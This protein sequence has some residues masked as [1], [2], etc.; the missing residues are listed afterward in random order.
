M[1]AMENK[2][3]DDDKMNKDFLLLSPSRRSLHRTCK[4]PLKQVNGNQKKRNR[5]NQSTSGVENREY[6]SRLA[7]GLL[8]TFPMIDQHFDV[9]KK[10]GE[11]TFSKVYLARYGKDHRRLIAIKHLIPT[12]SPSRIENELNCLKMVGGRCNVIGVECTLRVDDHIVFLLPYLPHQ[13]FTN[14][15]RSMSNISI[16]RY[17]KNLLIALNHVHKHNIIHRD[18]KPNNFIYCKE[19]KRYSLI[20]FGLAMSVPGC[21]SSLLK[22]YTSSATSRSLQHL[23]KN[24]LS[25]VNLCKHSS[26]YVCSLCKSR[27]RQSAPRAGTPGFRSP[28]VLMR[29]PNQTTAVDIWSAGVILLCILSGRYPFFKVKDD[30]DALAQ[31]VALFKIQDMKKMAS[32]IGK[33]FEISASAKDPEHSLKTMCENL[34]RRHCVIHNS[35]RNGKRKRTVDS[36]CEDELISPN[37]KPSVNHVVDC[38]KSSDSARPRD[39]IN[40]NPVT[41]CRKDRISMEDQLN[42][43]TDKDSRKSTGSLDKESR[44]TTGRED[45]EAR[46]STSREDKE[47][48]KSTGKEYKE[49]R[50]STGRED[51]CTCIIDEA[52]DLLE[53][54]L[55]LDP[56]RRIN[57]KDALLH[58]FITNI[59]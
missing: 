2:K 49:S 36:S 43:I 56:T 26:R 14:Y 33:T 1:H 35:L 50:K 6:D 32:S 34:S 10:V 28:E 15:F 29:H 40:K 11:G 37:K 54:L 20:D 23:N 22:D 46:K 57:A 55:E 42:K 27:S 25:K 47:S 39:I 51:K 3:G 17:M 41:K 18:V 9:L 53:K 58:P 31:I 38:R 16:Q 13:K 59:I 5:P 7:S 4:S 21:K 19:F 45:K 48:R 12:S 8:K 30:Y 52:Y 24:N 44:K